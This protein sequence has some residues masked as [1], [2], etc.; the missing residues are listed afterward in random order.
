LYNKCNL[1]FV[2]I[3]GSEMLCQVYHQLPLHDAGFYH[4]YRPSI[5]RYQCVRLT[6]GRHDGQRV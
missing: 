4:F 6:S 2:C 3:S 1:T 5:I